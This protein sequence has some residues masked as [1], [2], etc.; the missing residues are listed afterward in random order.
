VN[1]KAEDLAFLARLVAQGRIRP[2]IHEV[3]PLS[4]IREAHDLSERGGV[5]GKIAVRIGL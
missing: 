4:A 3:F 5:R 1:P 2:E